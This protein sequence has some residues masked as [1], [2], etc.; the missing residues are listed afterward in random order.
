MRVTVIVSTI[1]LS[2]GLL[3]GCGSSEGNDKAGADKSTDDKGSSAGGYCA[4][5]KDAK[6]DFGT[7]ESDSPDF[8]KFDDAIAR[9]HELADGAPS[10]VA[11]DWKTLDSAL[12]AMEKALAD[13]GLKIEDLAAITAGN[14]PEGMT[15]EDVQA[16]GPKLQTAFSGLETDE[17]EKAGDAIEKHAKSECGVD[18]SK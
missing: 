5:L 12:S 17:V 16:L 11:E 2:A 9:F 13:A 10:A 7:L 14:L 15:A 4:E 1:V 3:A 18:L 8:S 6:A